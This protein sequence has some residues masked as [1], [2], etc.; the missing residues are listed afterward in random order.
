[1][2]IPSSEPLPDNINDLPP[3]RQRHIRRLPRSATPAELQILI[4]S[5]IKLTSPTFNFVLFTILGAIAVGG[6]L[7]FNNSTLFMVA[8]LTLPYP[9]PIFCLGLFPK[10]LKLGSALKSVISLLISITLILVSGA[11]AGWLQKT[12]NLSPL[13]ISRFTQP[14]LLN[15]V[16]VGSSA[17]LSVLIILRQGRL[18]RLIGALLSYEILIPLASAG[19]G[20]FLGDAQLWP[21]LLMTGFLHLGIALSMA[22]FAFLLFGFLPN[23]ALGWLSALVPLV[24]TL[25]LL[26]CGIMFD[27]QPESV[28]VDP[29]P[30][31]T[32]IAIL[33]DSSPTH[34]TSVYTP[35]EYPKAQS[36]TLTPSPLPTLTAS[37]TPTPSLTPVPTTY[38]G[39]V[40]SL[41]GA[42]IREAPDFESTVITYANNNDFI[43]IMDEITAIDGSRWFKVRTP[44]GKIGWLLSSLVNTP[45]PTVTP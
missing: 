39:L 16:I 30:S 24:L 28:V 23:K 38:W 40:D 14:D 7:Y 17:L 32:S 19:F 35:T 3:A 11:L 31:P 37:L 10:T 9:S 45:T 34:S 13:G 26:I 5:L 22:I 43:E 6:A 2:S 36:P 44:S 4:D 15:S 1:M 29:S 25:A 33:T 12:G 27:T 20:F 42:V 21:G 41:S 8:I 18:P